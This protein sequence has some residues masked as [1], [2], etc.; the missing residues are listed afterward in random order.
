MVFTEN[1]I[2]KLHE[3]WLSSYV[4][5][6]VSGGERLVG[7]APKDRIDPQRQ[8]CRYVNEVLYQ[9]LISTISHESPEQAKVC[10]DL[11]PSSCS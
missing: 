4:P 10:E 3:V 6:K 1:Q 2:D 5:V 9:A 11:V 8:P 7:T